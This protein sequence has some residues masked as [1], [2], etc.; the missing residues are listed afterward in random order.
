MDRRHAQQDR[1]GNRPRGRAAALLGAV[2]LLSGCL[3]GLSLPTMRANGSGTAPHDPAASRLVPPGE[4]AS[5]VIADL[6]T[7]QSVLPPDSAFDRVAR[8]V[9]SAAPG[10]EAAELGLARLRAEAAAHNRWPSITPAMTL[11][12]LAGLAAQI[13]VDQP[14]LDHG[15]RKAERDRALAEVDAA[16][17]TLAQRQ[18]ARVFDGLSLY[19]AAEQARAQGQV[20][21]GA[22]ARLSALRNIVLARIEGGL[23][24]TSEDQIIAQTLTEMQ[25]T[26]DADARTRTQAL[27]DLAA[28]AKANVPADLS[29]L[30]PV[31]APDRTDPLAILYATAQGARTLAEARIARAA[32]L[33][34]LS[35]TANIGEQG[36]TP[37]LNLGGVRLGP[38]SPAL[39]AA[40]N[41]APDLVARQIAES[42]H[43]ADRRRTELEGRI[44]TLRARREQG[45]AVL[46]QTKGN[47]D[48]Y[49]EQY[50]MG[51]R[52]LT[53]LTAQT[54]SVARLE[55]DQVALAYDIARAELELA[56][57]AGALVDGGDL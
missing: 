2:L 23:S 6:S 38:G 25:A 34:G 11:D 33:P 5:P 24:D 30:S 39:V 46:A 51:R 49:A 22:T 20:A 14:L 56:R 19:L 48:L 16:A 7:R 52:S 41:A 57:D 13:V 3:G 27:A 31:A 50:R 42:R 44:A 15:R 12:S 40:A 35:A 18:N 28:L 17:V 45:D 21:E 54:A 29:G 26:R 37:G 53:D 1:H 9:L 8:A 36:V 43:A 4:T 47:L 32:N 55:R 10:V